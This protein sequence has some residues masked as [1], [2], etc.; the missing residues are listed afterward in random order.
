MTES[1]WI[2]LV[3][4]DEPLQRQLA[5]ALARALPDVEVHQTPDADEALRLVRD[6]RSRLLITEAQSAYVDGLALATVARRNRPTLPVIFLG[7]PQLN[8]ARARIAALGASHLID[9]PPQLERFVSLAARLVDPPP[10]F[11]GEVATSDLMELVQLVVMTTPSGAL[12]LSS[13]Q[14]QGTVWLERGAIVHAVGGGERGVAAFRRMLRWSGGDF[15]LDREASAPE[16]TITFT[17][18]QLL[19]ES[20]RILD[21][22]NGRPREDHRSG[23][24][25][26]EHFE[27]GLEAVQAKQYAR[28]LPEWERAVALEPDNR[29]YQHNLARL[30]NV[31][32]TQLARGQKP[33]GG[34]E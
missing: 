31:I 32:Q 25:A 12:H 19:L 27:L 24:R 15:Q 20:A 4:D 18:T 29:M 9:K 6:G 1:T 5:G 3:E 34:G 2:V 16:R 8:G 22:E 11:R 26:V 7:G 14:G 23:E 17:T 13:P 21:E 33:P 10:G 28:A 30:R